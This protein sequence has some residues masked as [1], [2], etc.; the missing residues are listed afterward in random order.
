MFENAVKPC[1][2]CRGNARGYGVGV[3]I[4]QL[5]VPVVHYGAKDR[6]QPCT[7]KGFE[8]GGIHAARGDIPHDSV[9]Y[10]VQGSPFP[11]L[12]YGC[13]ASGQ[14]DGIATV[15]TQGGDDVLVAPTRVGHHGTLKGGRI[16]NPAPVYH[17]RDH[18]ELLLDFAGEHAA[19]VDQY[20]GG[21]GCGE[22]L[23]ECFQLFGGFHDVSAYLADNQIFHAKTSFRALMNVAASFLLRQRGGSSL[24]MF[25]P[26]T[27][28][29]MCLS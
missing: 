28:V 19:S 25:F 24:I 14:A 22:L 23:A 15:F 26:A 12:D 20:L 4:Q 21:G 3:G 5:S 27:P 9:V 10:T 8:H 13:V 11:R 6:H 29:K 2:H 1:A 17:I 7:D 18:T 16:G